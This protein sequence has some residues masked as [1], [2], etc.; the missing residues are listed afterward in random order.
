MTDSDD[1]NISQ[2]HSAGPRAGSGGNGGQAPRSSPGAVGLISDPPA[3]QTET[4]EHWARLIARAATD[5]IIATD[6]QGRVVFWNRG[7]ELLGGYSAQEMVGRRLDAVIPRRNHLAYCSMLRDI[8]CTHAPHWLGKPFLCLG[9]HKSGREIPLEVS[10]SVWREGE[11]VLLACIARDATE[12][13]RAERKLADDR[14]QLER[15]VWERT[16]ELH[17]ISQQLQQEIADRVTARQMLQA[18]RQRIFAVLDAMPAQVFL[19]MPDYTIH[20]A[21]RSFRSR[22]GNPDGR[23]CHE[24]MHGRSASCDSCP[25]ASVFQTRQPQVWQWSDA[26]GRIYQ[27]YNYP[28]F[29]LDGSMLVLELSV[30]IT[31]RKRSEEALRSAHHHLTAAREQERK[32]LA[33]ELHDS[34]GQELVGIKLTLQNAMAEVES[35]PKSLADML[36]ATAAKC[37]SLVREVRNICYGL[38]PP[39]LEVFGLLAALRQLAEGMPVP[40]PVQVNCTPELEEARFPAETEIALFRIA[41]EALNNALRH[42]LAR[43]MSLDIKHEDGELVLTIA[44]DGIGFDPAAA[45]GKGMG[46]DSMRGRVRTLGGTFRIT[47][48]P[49]ATR[50][51]ARVP[52]ALASRS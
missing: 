6:G 4:H 46:L 10:I 36:N 7:A 18:E 23:R 30:D 44:D 1:V 34:L 12:R 8:A 2:S 20:F 11:R 3:R 38:Y 52:V 14:D 39:R 49:G 42:G 28:F 16:S 32:R 43:Q 27:V 35:M 5:A 41:Q 45:S 37:A 17:T 33:R 24:L 31:R 48:Q 40:Q 9:L 29:E 26:D 50:V 51:E 21:N 47:S 19:M 22:Y 13:H 25:A 15:L